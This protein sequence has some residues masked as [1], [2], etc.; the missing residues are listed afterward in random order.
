MAS[1]HPLLNIAFAS[2]R[3]LIAISQLPFQSILDK[4]RFPPIVERNNRVLKLST[5]GTNKPFDFYQPNR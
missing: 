2:R 3:I 1:T 5:F 4:L